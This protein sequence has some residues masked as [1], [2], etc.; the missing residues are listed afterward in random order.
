[1]ILVVASMKVELEGLFGLDRSPGYWEECKLK[2]TGIGRENVNETFDSLE[3]DSVLDGLLSV[4]FVGSVDP[5]FKPGELCLIESIESENKEGRLLPDEALW[6]RAK[7]SLRGDYKTCELLTV[8]R[9]LTSTGE[10]CSL[11]TDQFSII[12]RETYWVAEVAEEEAVPFLSM[13]VV[14]DGIDQGLPPE[15]CY[16]GDTGNVKPG[17]FT[18]WLIRNPS[19]LGEIPRLG[20]NSVKARRRLGEGLNDVIPALLG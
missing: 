2:Y 20:W 13:R 15:Y 12:D 1:M 11:G 17:S 18:S 16:D 3:F 10:K 6:T 4:G 19:R 9:T 5:D 8:D 7:K 14:F